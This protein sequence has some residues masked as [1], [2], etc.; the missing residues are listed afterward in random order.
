MPTHDLDGEVGPYLTL[1]ELNLEWDFDNPGVY[2][3]WITESP[4]I[5]T[6]WSSD[7]PVSE[8]KDLQS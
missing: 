7:I 4:E 2:E 1:S 8:M 6:G 3:I 5:L